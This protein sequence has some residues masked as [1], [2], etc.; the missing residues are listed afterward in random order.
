VNSLA[1]L[2]SSKVKIQKAL[3]HYGS[4]CKNK[5]LDGCVINKARRNKIALETGT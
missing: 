4:F 5:I 2:F 1:K 3:A